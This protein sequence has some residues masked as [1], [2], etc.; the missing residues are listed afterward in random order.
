MIRASEIASAAAR[1]TLSATRGPE[2]EERS[3][4]SLASTVLLPPPP[5]L[6]FSPSVPNP[7]HGSRSARRH[8]MRLLSP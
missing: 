8:H 1:E 6:S 7:S 5:P 2:A 4:E 3:T